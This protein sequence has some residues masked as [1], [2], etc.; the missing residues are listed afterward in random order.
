MVRDDKRKADKTLSRLND[1]L[2][3]TLGVEAGDEDELA[4]AVEQAL[5]QRDAEI[6]R[7]ER[8]RS[9]QGE[10]LTELQTVVK[11]YEEKFNQM[12][13]PPLLSG[14]VL[15]LHGPDLGAR[16]LSVHSSNQVLKVNAGNLDK[17]ELRQGQ[18]VWLHPKTYAVIAQSQTFEQ[19]IVARVADILPSHKLVVTMGEG[20]EKKVI[21]TDPALGEEIKI[22]Y[23]VSLLPPT[24]EILEVR[25]S[26]EIRDLFLGEKPNVSYSQVGGLDQVIDRIR[27]VVELPY[28]EPEVFKKIKLKP[29]KGTL[30]YGP[31]GCG[32]TLIAKAVATENDMTYFNVKIADVL[33]KWVGESENMI[34]AIFKKARECAPS[35]I[36]FDE[37]DA[38]GTT[39]GQ[40]DTAGVHKN[41]IAQIL[42]EMDGVE[43]LNDVF[44]LAATNRPDMIDPALMRPGRFDEVI[45]IPRPNREGAE[46]ILG[47]YL[48]DD[49]P[50]P[51]AEVE[52]H[53]SQVAA[54][55]A[56]RKAVISELYDENKW[57]EFKLDADA[58]ESVKTIKRKDIVSGALIQS[59]VATAKKNYV[60]RIVS[61]PR[62]D[63]RRYEDGLTLE[64]LL[65]AV[66]EESK[67]HAL[68]E[69]SV[70]QKRQRE[71]A[72]FREE[73]AEVA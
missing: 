54:I 46:K 73:G 4:G 40:Q 35:I 15:R 48:T 55:G 57:V 62:D 29:P 25:P 30:L 32:K 36:F 10:E 58:K 27:D 72:R 45:E 38:I 28:R 22:G 23:E 71:R 63:P 6:A 13:E 56:L 52:R 14:Y 37:F 7:L 41:I 70:Y 9:A 68:V 33:S 64:D 8:Q 59:I 19:G 53:G 44:I 31:P 69:S 20:F 67:E 24:Y 16:E 17:N 12:K 11:A 21:D 66:E 50:V 5:R 43:A 49:L 65:K 42:S 1:A 18:Y 2:G 3:K 61:L 47:I 26:S 34:K 39:R 51:K 60:K